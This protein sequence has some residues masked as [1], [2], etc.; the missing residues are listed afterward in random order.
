MEG[1]TILIVEDSPTELALTRKALQA[2]GFRIVTAVDGEEALLQV[3]AERPA[4]VF[5]DVILPKKSGFQVCRELKS[6][7][8]TRDIKVVLVTSKNQDSDRFWGLKQGADEY[9]TKPYKDEDLL[10]VVA[11]YL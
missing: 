1:G 5:L 6:A 7:P 9:L 10:A 2:S 3:R 8:E 11:R 4:L